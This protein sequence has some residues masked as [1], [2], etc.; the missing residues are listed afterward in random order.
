MS[1]ASPAG[2]PASASRWRSSTGRGWRWWPAC[3]WLG[4]LLEGYV[5]YPRFLGDRVEL[6]AVWV[7]FALF[8]GG[9]AFGFL[10]VLLAVPVAA[11]IGVLARFWLRRYLRQPACISIRRPANE[12][13]RRDRAASS[14]CA[15]PRRPRFAAAELLPNAAQRGGAAPGWTRAGDWPPAGWRCGASRAAASRTCC[16]VWA[17]RHG[18]RGAAGRAGAT[19]GRAAPVAIDDIDAVPDEPA[20]LHLLNAA[21][22]A[23]QPVLLVA[24]MPPGAA[25]G[26][27][28]PT[29]PAG[30]A[31]PPPSNRPGRR[32]L[33]G[34]AAGA[35]AGRAAD[36]GRRAA[37]RAGCSRGCRARPAAIRDAV[38]RLDAPRWPP[39]APSPAAWRRT[40]LALDDDLAASE[41]VR[42]PSHPG[43]GLDR[44]RAVPEEARAARRARYRP[45][46]AR[47]GS[48]TASCP[49]ST[50][51]TAW[52]RRR[53]TR[54][55]RCWS[56]CASSR[57]ALAT[58]TSSSR[59]RV[60][61]LIG[62][63]KAGRRARSA[64][65]AAP[66][67][68]QLGEI[69]VRAARADGRAAARLARPARPAARRRHRAV[70]DSRRCPTRTGPGSRS[71]SWTGCS[72]C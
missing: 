15:F 7:I 69:Q 64:P 36:P 5:I 31:P 10:G 37:C 24:R 19:R 13:C 51:T 52:S 18:R 28:C 4:Q 32:R 56:G 71:G 2:S 47:T 26:R 9:A 12:A 48:S 29:W 8:A 3:S 66:P 50:S 20:L 59:V 41:P 72:R 40:V 45:R 42:S 33:P 43:T 35:P 70:R 39:G 61:G 23:G 53:R 44:A 68:Q 14:R 65:T 67:A 30:C 63:A 49:G 46:R 34:A 1:A 58:S 27:A 57:S 60:A 55:I 11:A 17:A 21:A 54:A 16:H 38:A 6:H 22:E 62:Q 25:A